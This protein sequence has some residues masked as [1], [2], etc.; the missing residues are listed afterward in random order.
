MLKL[1]MEQNA[2]LKEMEVELEM[3]LKEKEQS[4]PMKVIPL[5]TIPLTGVSIA[6]SVETPSANPLTTLEKIVELAK[7]MEGMNL[8]EMEINILK[9]EVESLQGLKSS[10]Q[11]SYSM[12]K[13]T[14][15]KIKQELQ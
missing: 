7:S 15:D 14:S 8:Q 13:Q 11:T 2:Q 9:K 1:I 6:S 10:Y 12:E 5:R 4:K 3:L